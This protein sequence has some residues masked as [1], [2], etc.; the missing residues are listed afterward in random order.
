MTSKKIVSETALPFWDT[1]GPVPYK[2]SNDYMFR[3]VLQQN[4]KALRGLI[5]SLLHLTQQEIVSVK[6]TNPVIL[7]ESIG[8]KEF[9]LDVNVN[10]NN[11]T[12]INLEM[13]LANQLNWKDRSLSYL[14]RS[15]DQLAHGQD[16]GV[17]YPVIHIGILDYPLFPSHPEFY[18]TFQLMNPKTLQVYSSHFTLRVLDLTH[19]SLAVKEDKDFHTD[20]WAKLFKANTWEEIKMLASENESIAEAAKT[21]FELSTDEQI[22]KRCR[23]REEYYQDLKNYDRAIAEN[24]RVIAENERTI[25]ENKHTI[26]EN[27]RVIAES[28]RVIAENERMI[29]ENEHTI[30]ENERTITKMQGELS[31]TQAKLTQANEKLSELEQI[32]V[33]AEA[34]GYKNAGV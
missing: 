8:G 32:A 10:L 16:Y 9:R 11:N 25:A 34:H 21:M 5:C 12:F 31:D 24:K 29:A 14:C 18:S 17:I 4:N 15:F 22:R 7:G 20:S 30:A 26:A 19:I 28:K 2:M 13:Q 27:K 33:W 6:I 3:A 23:D 1:C